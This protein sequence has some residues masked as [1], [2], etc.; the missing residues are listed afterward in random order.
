MSDTIYY[1]IKS[2]ILFGKE[3][4]CTNG[5]ENYVQR[6]TIEMVLPEITPKD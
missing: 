1:M 2:Q 5:L 3:D 4:S 6:V